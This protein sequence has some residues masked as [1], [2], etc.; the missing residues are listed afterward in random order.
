VINR[1]IILKNWS[2]YFLD[3]DCLIDNGLISTIALAT[4]KFGVAQ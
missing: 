2:T 4:R 1:V 3:F